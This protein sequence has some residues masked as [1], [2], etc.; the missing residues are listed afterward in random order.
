[1]DVAPQR[2]HK[3]CNGMNGKCK[4]LKLVVN[5]AIDCLMKRFCSSGRKSNILWASVPL[6]PWSASI[7]YSVTDIL[8]Y[9]QILSD[10]LRYSQIY[11]W[12]IF[13]NIISDV[14]ADCSEAGED[15]YNYNPWSCLHSLQR[16]YKATKM[17]QPFSNPNH[18]HQKV[19][20]LWCYLVFGVILCYSVSPFYGVSC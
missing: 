7:V 1:M 10:I 20:V 18:I 9:S 2:S 6:P 15:A 4:K 14:L 5:T 8:K 12:Q 3:L 19:P 17:L 13:S 11:Q 16:P